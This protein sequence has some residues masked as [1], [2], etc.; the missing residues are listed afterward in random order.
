MRGASLRSWGGTRTTTRWTRRTSR[1]WARRGPAC[2]S[3]S[4]CMPWRGCVRFGLREKGV[5]STSDV[6]VCVFSCERARCEEV[7]YRR[8]GRSWHVDRWDSW[9]KAWRVCGFAP[10]GVLR[11]SFEGVRSGL[12]RCVGRGG[13]GGD[14]LLGFFCGPGASKPSVRGRLYRVFVDA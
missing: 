1:G 7:R 13:F 6:C 12:A 4:S 3:S 9:F 11:A 5:W 2:G 8:A 14:S 10:S